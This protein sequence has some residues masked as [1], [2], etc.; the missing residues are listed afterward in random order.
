MSREKVIAAGAI[1]FILLVSSAFVFIFPQVKGK[2]AGVVES[3]EIS[4]AKAGWRSAEPFALTNYMMRESD[5]MLILKNNSPRELEFLKVC[6]SETE[7]VEYGEMLAPQ[8]TVILL[9]TAGESCEPGEEY[10]FGAGGI[11]FEYAE[12]GLESVQ[13]GEFPVVGKCA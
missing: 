12:K 2:A 7:C 5:I 3:L 11:T 1:V 9:I 6:V 4:G 8:E 10:S 13:T